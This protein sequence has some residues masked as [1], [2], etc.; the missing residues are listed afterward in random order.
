[1]YFNTILKYQI[2][3]WYF[4]FKFLFLLKGFNNS[5]AKYQLK[6]GAIPS[7]FDLRN[8]SQSLQLPTAETIKKEFFPTE[9]ILIFYFY[10]YNI[11]II[12]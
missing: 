4:K 6:K 11:G 12:Y 2:E 8:I 10:F 7:I 9:V 5:R 1:M 3:C